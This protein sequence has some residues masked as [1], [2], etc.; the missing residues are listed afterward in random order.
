MSDITIQ[1]RT[2]PGYQLKAFANKAKAKAFINRAMK[3]QDDL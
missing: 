3:L 1:N 2:F